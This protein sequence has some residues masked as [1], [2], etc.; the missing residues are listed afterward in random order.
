MEKRR[1]EAALLFLADGS[2]ASPAAFN[3]DLDRNNLARAWPWDRIHGS[4]P[5]AASGRWAHRSQWDVC[6][7]QRKDPA[8]VS[9][10]RTFKLSA[11]HQ[12]GKTNTPRSG[13]RS[14]IPPLESSSRHRMR[15]RAVKHFSF[16]GALISVMV[17]ERKATS[18][19]PRP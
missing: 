10:S 4:R 7:W 5:E 6:L 16:N 8:L 1:E 15:R 13:Q 3:C 18:C 19:Q 9:P 2:D 14:S 12:D 11:P 17:R